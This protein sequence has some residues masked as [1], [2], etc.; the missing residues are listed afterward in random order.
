M[1]EMPLR[2]A[3]DLGSQR[4]PSADLVLM[5]SSTLPKRWRRFAS[6]MGR[7]VPRTRHTRT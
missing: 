3:L 7:I 6:R 4:S 5:S 2:C 1:R